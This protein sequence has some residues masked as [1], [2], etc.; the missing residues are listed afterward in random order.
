MGL[1]KRTNTAVFAR[2]YQALVRPVLEYA[3]PVWSPYLVSKDVKALESIQ[4]RASTLALKQKCGEMHY[5]QR[6]LLLKCDTLEK[7]RLYSSNVIKQC[8]I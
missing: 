7:H 2:L 5:E 6:C 4:R 1:I 8:L 3:T